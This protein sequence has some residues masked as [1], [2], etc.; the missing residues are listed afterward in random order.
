MDDAAGRPNAT[1]CGTVGGLWCDRC[2]EPAGA[3]AHEAC[4]TA[5]TLEPPRYCPSCRRRM[6][7]QVL[8]TGWRATCVEHGA[9]KD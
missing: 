9:I 3:S 1:A 5:R 8:P 4:R 6:K 2:G 7:V